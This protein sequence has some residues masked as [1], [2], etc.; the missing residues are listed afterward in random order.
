M[1]NQPNEYTVNQD[2][3]SDYNKLYEEPMDDDI[4]I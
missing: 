4:V 3:E 1:K 2:A